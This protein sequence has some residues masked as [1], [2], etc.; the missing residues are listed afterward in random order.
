MPA[1]KDALAFLADEH[2]LLRQLF[3]DFERPR[4]NDPRRSED[5]VLETGSVLCVYV[6]IEDELFYPAAA[7]ALADDPHAEAVMAEASVSRAAIAKATEHLEVEPPIG[8]ELKMRF[9]RLAGIARLHFDDQEKRLFPLLRRAGMDLTRLGARMAARR[10]ELSVA[11][12]VASPGDTEA[13]EE[14]E[15]EVRARRPGSSRS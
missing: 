2:V 7:A 5:I 14:R 10:V 12:G 1:S 8:P 3:D 6:Q 15:T 11:L 13:V 9:A 4:A